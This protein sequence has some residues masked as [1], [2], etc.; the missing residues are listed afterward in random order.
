MFKYMFYTT[1]ATSRG[2]KN[3][4]ITHMGGRRVMEEGVA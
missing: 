4:Y 1:K 3:N 2:I